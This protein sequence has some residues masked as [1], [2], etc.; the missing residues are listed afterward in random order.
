MNFLTSEYILFFFVFIILMG[1]S[2]GSFLN[3]C[4]YRIPRHESL[5]FPGS[6]CPNCM[7][8]IKWYDNIPVLSFILLK[9]KCRYCGNKI[10]VR[11]PFIEMLNCLLWVLMF[12]VSDDLSD[13]LLGLIFSSIL[14]VISAIDMEKMEIPDGLN[15]AVLALAII[16]FGVSLIMGNELKGTLIDFGVGALSGSILLYLLYLLVLKLT[17]KE[18]L[19]GGDVKLAF[20]CGAFLGWKEVLFG[21]ALSA[22]IGLIG[23]LIY[24]LVK[25]KMIKGNFP[26]GPFLSAGFLISYMFFDDIFKWYMVTFL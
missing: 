2:V 11:Y 6:H 10:S 12:L 23:I 8:N 5:A 18:G 9:G 22:Y 21:I 24:S 14:I 7:K 15:V 20:A 19:G 1:L 26:Y 25:K 16:K 4:I 17:K 13:C 3:V